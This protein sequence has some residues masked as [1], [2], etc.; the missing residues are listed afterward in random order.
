MEVCPQVFELIEEKSNVIGPD[1]C[2]ACD[3][4]G[5]IDACPVQAI[6]WEESSK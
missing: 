6:R 3:C 5:A 2:W 1:K 4:Q